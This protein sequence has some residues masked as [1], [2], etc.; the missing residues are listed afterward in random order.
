MTKYKRL[1]QT[2]CKQ[3]VFTDV[4]TKDYDDGKYYVKMIGIITMNGFWDNYEINNEKSKFPFF[5]P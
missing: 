3:F 1:L 5:S 2:T 4:T